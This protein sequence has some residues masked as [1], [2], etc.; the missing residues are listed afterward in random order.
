M[1]N[2]FSLKINW[3]KKINHYSNTFLIKKFTVVMKWTDCML[4]AYLPATVYM[5]E[6][7]F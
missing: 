3:Y 7:L 4:Y 5:E 6:I 1:Q 2:I